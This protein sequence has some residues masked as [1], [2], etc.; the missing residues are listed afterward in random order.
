MSELP[1][2]PNIRLRYSRR[3]V[4]VADALATMLTAN[5]ATAAAA[6]AE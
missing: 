4:A 1:N 6:A 5:S 2:V 3:L